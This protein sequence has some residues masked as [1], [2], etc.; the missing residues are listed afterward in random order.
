MTASD[1]NFPPDAPL[2]TPKIDYDVDAA[3]E[4]GLGANDIAQYLASE[5][6]YDY[7]GA[8][9]AGVTDDQII[10]ELSGAR[11][12]SRISSAIEGA[13]R[14]F[15][16]AVPAFAAG[17]TGSMLGLQGGTAL[18]PLLGPAAPLGPAIGFIGGGTL[19]TIAGLFAG[20]SAEKGLEEL[21]VLPEGPLVPGLRPFLEGGRTFGAGAPALIAP[22][23]IVRN[24]PLGTTRFLELQAPKAVSPGL[25]PLDQILRSAQRRPG[26]FAA[27]ETSALGASALGGGLAEQADPGNA[28]LRMGAE[29]ALGMTN[30]V[31][32][33]T[34][35]VGPAVDGIKAS[36]QGLTVEGRANR[37]GTRLVEIL[38]GAGE[39]PQ[40]VITAL[41]QDDELARIADEM[42]VDL[43][44]RTSAL[45]SGSTTLTNLQRTIAQNNASLG[46]TVAR[47]AEQN[48][49]GISRLINLMAQLE[50][51]AILSTVAQMRDAYFRDALQMRLDQASSRAAETAGKILTDDPLAGQR[52][53]ETVAQIVGDALS[54]ARAQERALY[55]AIDL[56]Q[57]AS[58]TNILDTVAQIKGNILPE[59]PFPA[60]IDRFA[61][62]VGEE[63][64]EVSLRDITNFRSEMLSM[65]RDAAATGNFRDANFFGRMAE[66]ALED[67]GLRAEARPGGIDPNI[68]MM[69]SPNQRALENAYAFSRSLNDVFTRS[70]AG[71]VG[72]R[73]RTGANRIPPELLARRVF[74]G[75]GDA[76]SLRISQLEE[77]ANF[78]ANNAGPEFAETATQRLGTLRDAEQTILQVA[79][80]RTINPETGQVNPAALSRFLR[81]NAAALERFPNLRSDLENA[82][83]AQ[84]RLK[85]VT[86]ANSVEAR[87][88]ENNRVFSALLGAEETP[89]G[90]IGLA[91]GTPGEGRRP[92]AVRNLNQLIRLTNTAGELAPQARA[93]LRDAVMDRAI[94]YATDQDGNFNFGRFRNFLLEPISRSQPSVA[95]VLREGGIFTDTEL[96]QLNRFLQ[97]AD[98]IQQALDAGGPRLEETVID[99]PAAAFDLVTRI[100]GSGVGT[101]TSR[102]L[103]RIIPF[104]RRGGGQGLIEAQAGSQIT[105]NMFKNMP[106]TYL[107]DM[108]NEAIAD[109]KIMADLLERGTNNSARNRLRI[110]RRINAWLFNAGLQPAREEIEDAQF[111]MPLAR[112]AE[113]ATVDP[114]ALQA[115][116]DSVQPSSPA[117]APTATPPAPSPQP[118]Q[119]G[120]LPPAAPL[121]QPPQAGGSPQT[122]QQYRQMFPNDMVSDMIPG[123]AFGGPVYSSPF[124]SSSRM[125]L[126]GD[127]MN[128]ASQQPS[129]GG[130]MSLQA[131]GFGGAQ[132][133]TTSALNQYGAA[134][135]QK[136]I[137]PINRSIGQIIQGAKQS[138]QSMLGGQSTQSAAPSM[139]MQPFNQQSA[140]MQRAQFGGMQ[141]PQQPQM[142]QPGML[143]FGVLDINAPRPEAPAMT[144][145]QLAQRNSQIASILSQ[146]GPQRSVLQA[147]S[148]SMASGGITSL[149]GA[150]R[151][152]MGFAF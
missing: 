135:Q 126:Q 146:L 18:A 9:A 132:D 122:R 131:S 50:D 67:I 90:A 46:P 57:P 101:A 28:Y 123:F 34:R 98:N 112:P 129:G 11:T 37:L 1:T 108:L 68:P 77:A 116:L 4:A 8:R 63:G 138:E 120:A 81:D 124:G 88:M 30:P 130:I 69:K 114:A 39:D 51:P 35:F 55:Q 73:S 96:T 14:G 72:A 137:E 125:A 151:L 133:S 150:M 60:L 134:L 103:E 128:Q 20:E 29:I 71:D 6:N 23:L 145:Q 111:R 75:G 85:A 76:T 52:A 139:Q 45:R 59:S 49:E 121:P 40:A 86:D 25:G 119:Q 48:L 113:A 104:Y 74:S 42:G 106:Q 21:G 102:T 32:I 109:P 140:F 142:N 22:Q 19:G 89:G 83:T 95:G 3:L 61:A 43:G 33:V 94:V 117:P 84:Q 10:E 141:A 5:T 2:A 105:Q 99:A 58:A 38:E 41:L 13:A 144:D 91:I 44:P 92:D 24:M 54:D 110:D 17:Y 62:R 53:G 97:E 36:I 118:S 82:V 147:P 66:A 127:R 26:M 15:V 70:F 31:G 107:R 78:L 93:G 80:Q 149:Q 152:P 148:P 56:T 100:L 12:S 87:A 65:A 115:Y 7:E 79:A 64:A 16:E 47:A 136:Y 143:Q 27:G